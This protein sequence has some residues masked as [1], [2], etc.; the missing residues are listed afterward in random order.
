MTKEW[1]GILMAGGAGT[2]LAPVTW[3]FSKHLLPIYDKPMIFYSLAILMLA[4]I[5]EV[6][7]I[8]TAKDLIH[9]EVILG[10]GKD[11]GINIK[12]KIQAE[13]DGIASAFILGADFVG[14]ANVCLMLGDNVFYGQGLPLLLHRGMEGC[15][16]GVVYAYPV[17]DPE[18]FGVVEL[19]SAGFPIHI[20]E[21]PKNP[22]S[23]LALTG[24][25]FYRND[26]ISKARKLSLSHRGEREITDI[27]IQYLEE[28][29]LDVVTLGR[30][31]AWLDTGTHDSLMEASQFVKTI[32]ERQGYKIGCLEEIA[33]RS[34]WI[35]A[36][37]LIEKA[38]SLSK[39]KYG[40]YLKR[41]S[42]SSL[43]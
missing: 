14:A 34:G 7:I 23:N 1:K 41:L 29:K 43:L 35:S 19:D 12:Y 9:Y 13:P 3:P 39:T 17:A 36:D 24:L 4:G 42:E 11:L 22:R 26:V 28:K 25:Y 27:N 6:L 33:F 20:A 37:Q 16:G 31:V 15:R 10:D 30:G 8:C 40:K 38:E 5:R 2:R 32:E 21:K 18:R